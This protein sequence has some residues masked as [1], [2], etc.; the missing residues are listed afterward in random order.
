M[1]SELPFP[2]P[3]HGTVV[4]YL[5]LFVALGGTAYAAA[6]IGSAQVIDDSLRSVD[7]KDNAA[8]LSRDVVNDTV[9]GGGL[10][11]ADV[12]NN[13]LTSTDVAGLTGADVTDN[14]LTGADIN[15]S[16]LQGFLRDTRETR[17]NASMAEWVKTNPASPV[18]ANQQP[19][20]TYFQSPGTEKLVIASAP[21]LP[22]TVAGKPLKLVG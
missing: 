6:T 20:G 3:R 22:S 11:G 7:L 9:T 5:A 1:L 16:T 10:A 12:R 21:D 18:T 19:G 2:R 15:E 8:V 17:I 13:S 14:S 4:A